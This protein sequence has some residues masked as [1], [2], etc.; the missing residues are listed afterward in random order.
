MFRRLLAAKEQAIVELQAQL[1][2]RNPVEESLR[3]RLKT[4]SQQ[5][6]TLTEQGVAHEE[7]IATLSV[8]LAA[9]V[10]CEAALEGQIAE[11]ERSV[12]TLQARAAAIEAALAAR[13]HSIILIHGRIAAL[14]A[15]LAAQEHAASLQ[16]AAQ[17]HAA[18]LQLAAQEHAA[19]LQLAA[20]EHEI[21]LLCGQISAM[22]SSNS[23][24]L[25]QVLRRARAVVA[26]LGSANDRI[27]QLA[28]HAWYLWRTQGIFGLVKKTR[29][30]ATHKA[31]QTL[32]STIRSVQGDSCLIRYHGFGAFVRK[33]RKTLGKL[34]MRDR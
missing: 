2:A 18:S 22:T 1:A 10:R 23:W 4:M 8:D 33:L 20:Q 25:V 15:Q 31:C 19:S 11:R 26:P 24:K 34:A 5:L 14:E 27:W 29:G 7:Q 13:N 3:A 28:R 6:A 21:A 17:E 16:L 9:R 30:K 12:E 32:A